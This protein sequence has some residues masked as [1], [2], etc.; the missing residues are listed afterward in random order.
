MSS[1]LHASPPVDSSEFTQQ[2]YQRWLV[3]GKGF[4]RI[5][6]G[7]RGYDAEDIFQTAMLS[8]LGKKDDPKYTGASSFGLFLGFFRNSCF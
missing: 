2:V 7:I 8:Y 1:T 4:A 3:Y 6:F 5:R